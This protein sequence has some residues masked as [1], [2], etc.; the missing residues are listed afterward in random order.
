MTRKVIGVIAAAVIAC[1]AVSAAGVADA[2]SKKRA[3]VK[4]ATAKTAPTTTSGRMIGI[5]VLL[6][7]DIT[8]AALADISRF[9]RVRDTIYEI[10]ALT[11]QAREADLAKIQALPYVAAANPDA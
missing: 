8:N 3:S 11:L 2:A 5:N 1:V 6:N 7:Q 10:D 4:A 9:G